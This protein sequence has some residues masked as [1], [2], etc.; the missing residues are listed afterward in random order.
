MGDPAGFFL[1]GRVHLRSLD[2]CQGLQRPGGQVRVHQQRHVGGKQRIP[3]EQGH[4]PWGA[5][6]NR[7][8]V[9]VL[10]IK[11]PQGAQITLAAVQD[12][13]NV[14][15]RDGN[16]RY[17]FLPGDMP[18]HARPVVGRRGLG[19]GLVRALSVDQRHHDDGRGPVS[20]GRNIH[21]ESQSI[22]PDVRSGCPDGRA[23]ALAVTLGFDMQLPVVDGSCG[24]WPRLA[25]CRL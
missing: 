14:P 4:E 16:A 6:G 25:P 2:P 23:P 22:L 19:K 13:L 5:G 12:V 18:L 17:V 20:P 3:A 24:Q 8:P 15:V 11:D 21:P 10:G 9:R 1:R 7:D